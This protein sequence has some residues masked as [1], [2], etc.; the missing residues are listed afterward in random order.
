[1]SKHTP[2]PWRLERIDGIDPQYRILASWPAVPYLDT[3][4]E[5]PREHFT[6]ESP[7]IVGRHEAKRGVGNIHHTGNAERIVACVNA[8]E[9]INPE[10]VPELLK[11]AKTVHD[12]LV[13]AQVAYVSAQGAG[14][15]I[16]PTHAKDKLSP[17]T[18]VLHA[19][20]TKAE[21]G[22]G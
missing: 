13:K 19:A 11:A 6:P 10:A 16:A 18:H 8:C 4:P 17:C 9:G 3:Q 14:R 12:L 21:A 20:I 22:S 7:I 15:S 1:M 5:S 2:G